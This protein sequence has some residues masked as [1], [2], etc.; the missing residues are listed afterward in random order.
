MCK[1]LRQPQT[2][3]SGTVVYGTNVQRVPNGLVLRCSALSLDTVE[4]SIRQCTLYGY[5]VVE[6]LQCTA[7][8]GVYCTAGS[9]AVSYTV[10][11][12]GPWQILTIPTIPHRRTTVY[13]SNRSPTPAFNKHSLCNM[14]PLGSWCIIYTTHITAPAVFHSHH[15]MYPQQ[16]FICIYPVP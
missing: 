9:Q 16:K 3:F 13:S 15:D 14:C 6:Y 7:V 8:S 12:R 10:I 4:Y 11:I 2:S 5:T 1:D